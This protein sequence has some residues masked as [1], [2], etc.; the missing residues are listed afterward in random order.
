ME[1]KDYYK[2]LGVDRTA[3]EQEI[4][5]AYRD[6][7]KKYHP[8]HNPGN[9]QAEEKF[10]EVNEAYEVLGD[11]K[12]RARYD[13]MGESYSRWQQAGGNPGNFNWTDWY[14]QAPG[15]RVQVDNL[16]DLFGGGFSDF[17]STFF[18]G[19]SQRGARSP[20]R[21]SVPHYEQPVTVSLLEAY[22]GC[23]RRL[24]MGETRLD[25]TIPPGVRTGSKV[26]VKAPLGE[27]GQV[28]EIYLLVTV[29]PDE[30]FERDGDDLRSEVS[31]DLFTAVLGG[32]A[33]ATTLTGNVLLTIPPGTQPGQTFRLGGRGMPRLRQPQTYGDLYVRVRVQ[34]PRQLNA[35][36]RQLFEQL[37]NA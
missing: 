36:Q 16:G 21:S 18:G 19:V 3:K 35:K 12:K 22:Q 28:N 7:A 11:P 26:R 33:L 6:L 2:I 30:R 27:N 25:V 23:Q 34:L 17:F 10:K 4:K 15:G 24:Q 37:R 5:R 8:D 20:A 13:Q 9:K 14:T 32:E 29:T 1:Y 31:I